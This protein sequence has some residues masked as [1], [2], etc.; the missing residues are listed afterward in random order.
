MEGHAINI[1]L[2]AMGGDRNPVETQVDPAVVAEA[3]GE[4]AHILLL[5]LHGVSHLPHLNPTI[6]EFSLFHHRAG[7]DDGV[8]AEYR[9]QSLKIF[10]VVEAAEILHELKNLATPAESST[11]RPPCIILS[12]SSWLSIARRTPVITPLRLS[13]TVSWRL[14]DWS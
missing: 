3:A 13:E 11:V 10:L 1:F 5:V 12:I 9:T 6:C 8:I 2:G 7:D 4:V 14:S